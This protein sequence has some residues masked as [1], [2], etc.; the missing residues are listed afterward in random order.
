MITR[1]EVVRDVVAAVASHELELLNSLDGLD[2]DQITEV[3]TRRRTPRDPVGFGVT[4][5]SVM[6]A[7]VV[8]IVVSEV[9]KRGTDVVADSL[10][11]RI[12]SWWQRLRGRGRREPAA[13]PQLTPQELSVVRLRTLQQATVAGIDDQTAERLADAVISAL[14]RGT[15]PA[16]DIEPDARE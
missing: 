12:R 9:V 15:G 8:W 1:R 4:E 5:A 13:V 14:A 16:P 7:P 3:L 10:F 2:E 6:V 11:A